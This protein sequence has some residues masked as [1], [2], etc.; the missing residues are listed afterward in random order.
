[1]KSVVKAG[2]DFVE[3]VI[4]SVDRSVEV[5][6]VLMDLT[7]AFDCVSHEVLLRKLLSMWVGVLISGLNLI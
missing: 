1:M 4:D 6:R 2:I 5:V 7:K 3:P